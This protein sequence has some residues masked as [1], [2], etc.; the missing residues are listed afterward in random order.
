MTTTI[1]CNL[2]KKL[3]EEIYKVCFKKSINN[4][5]FDFTI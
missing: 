2:T 5:Y 3:S 4:P 1:V